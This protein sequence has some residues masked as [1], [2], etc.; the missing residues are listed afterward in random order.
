MRGPV[1][2]LDPEAETTRLSWLL[3]LWQL[4]PHTGTCWVRR[5]PG[6]EHDVSL[7]ECVCRRKKRERVQNLCSLK[8]AW[9]KD[10]N[11]LS[12]AQNNLV[13]PG[14]VSMEAGD[15]TFHSSFLKEAHTFVFLLFF[16][17]FYFDLL[18]Q[19]ICEARCKDHRG[20]DFIAAHY[21]TQ[22]FVFCTILF[23]FTPKA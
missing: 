20:I 23:T 7:E 3:G 22:N 8:H 18:D 11:S 6:V 1:G 10:A 19:I 4:L 12:Q 21:N 15:W 14:D 2:S 13:T 16:L 17:Q 9:R 5:D